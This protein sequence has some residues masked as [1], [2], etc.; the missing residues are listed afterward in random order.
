MSNIE[1][2]L[3]LLD[4]PDPE[5]HATLVNRLSRDAEL[6]S[7]AWL[8]ASERGNSSAALTELVL[9]QDAEALMDAFAEAEHLEAGVWLL[10]R[11]DVPRRDYR[12]PGTRA[13]DELAERI[14]HGADPWSVARFLCDDWGLHRCAPGLRGSAQ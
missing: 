1:A 9:R 13:L 11:I 5:V 6:L 12:T 3:Q 14:G 4:D 2:L 8:F 7:Q 10:P